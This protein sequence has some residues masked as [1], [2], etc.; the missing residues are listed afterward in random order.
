MNIRGIGIDGFGRFAG[1][2]FEPLAPGLNV[3]YGSNEAGKSSLLA[4]IQTVLYGF[5]RQRRDAH[6]PPLNGGLH[7]GRLWLE[8]HDGLYV[9][10]RRAAPKGKD[11][12]LRLPGESETDSE[13][14]VHQLLGGATREVYTTVFAFSLDE[15]QEIGSLE[16]SEVSAQIYSAGIGA[17]AVPR[18]IGALKAREESLFKKRGRSHELAAIASELDEVQQRLAVQKRDDARYAELT[19]ERARLLRESEELSSA[20]ETAR[21]RRLRLQRL[22]EARPSWVEWRGLVERLNEEEIPR[23]PAEAVPQLDRIEAALASARTGH[24]AAIH[25]LERSRAAV[26]AMDVDTG[27]LDTAA[28]IDGLAAGLQSYQESVRD[29]PRR[30]AELR[31]QETDLAD[32]AGEMG[33][34]WTP[35]RCTGLDTSMAAR[36]RIGE[37]EQAISSA[38]REHDRAVMALQPLKAQLA[39]LEIELGQAIAARDAI[40]PPLARPEALQAEKA[41]IERDRIQAAGAARGPGLTI[42]VLVGATVASLVGTLGLYLAGPAGLVPG[43]LVGL[44]AG[45]GS[46]RFLSERRQVAPAGNSIDAI[47]EALAAHEA[48]AASVRVIEDS[49]RQLERLQARADHAATAVDA[50]RG[51]LD[52]AL[53]SWRMF[54]EAAQLPPGV[55]P[56]VAIDLLA[57]ARVVNEKQR[58]VK[59]MQHRV[60]A[61][62]VDIDRFD[63]EV[64]R[65]WKAA[66]RDDSTGTPEEAAGALIQELA[67][68]R[69]AARELARL[70]AEAKRLRDAE[71]LAALRLAEAETELRSHLERWEVESADALRERAAAFAERESLARDAR[72]HLA[73]VAQAAGS[74]GAI[75][76]FVAEL[77]ATD[78]V[79][80]ELEERALE[81][82]LDRQQAEHE[83]SLTTLGGVQGELAALESGGGTSALLARRERLRTEAAELAREWTTARIA[84]LL[85]EKARGRY[86]RER[87][88]AVVQ[89]A[90]RYFIEMTLGRYRRIIAP[91]G[92][93]SLHVVEANGQ[94]KTPDQLSRGTREQLYLALRFG[95]IEQ[96]RERSGPL[97]IVVD[98]VLVNFDR[99]RAL[100]AA[101]GFARLAQ[102][103]QV[104]AFTCHEWVVDLFREA[105][106]ATRVWMLDG[107]VQGGPKGKETE[108]V[109]GRYHAGHA[110]R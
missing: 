103:H 101:R 53:A 79:A 68:A 110:L 108:P 11:L 90:E 86:E 26:A 87:Q 6:Y 88:P 80:L 109:P 99:E 94:E 41:A 89:A 57:L 18:A 16:G 9:L 2:H 43:L 40:D 95:L 107:A 8:K 69:E 78:A 62:E 30:Q 67:G 33:A 70:E 106:G 76:A 35:A 102:R 24:S 20:I 96:F 28:A 10:Q 52:E 59:A 36:Q 31:A 66:H 29:L 74:H 7:G 27:M 25:E 50:A 54:A 37:H 15:L 1:T 71:E 38:R 85:I 58:S 21:E 63:A 61:I 3:F 49:A 105:D 75:D 39:D 13:E 34:G 48:L 72:E 22:R 73:R 23:V 19:V 4:F 55:S 56:G 14:A 83:V 64:A 42:Q 84:R 51:H 97:P 44:A 12:H 77:E 100:A 65:A 47:N 98:E 104:I 17:G 45:L 93:S 92:E 81:S 5:P 91:L 46:R 60:A 82:E 32:A